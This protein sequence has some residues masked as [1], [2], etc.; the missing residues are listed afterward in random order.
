MFSGITTLSSLP[1]LFGQSQ[2]DEEEGIDYANL[3]N[4]FDKYSPDQLRQMA[5][6]GELPQDEFPF[7]PYYAVAADGGRIGYDMG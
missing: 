6:A 2:E 4:I 5:L 1:L 7:Q 3:P